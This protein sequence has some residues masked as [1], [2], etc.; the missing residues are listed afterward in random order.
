[1]A[2]DTIVRAGGMYSRDRLEPYGAHLTKR[3]GQSKLT[4]A[5]AR[6]IPGGWSMAMARRMLDSPWLVRHLVIDRWFL[7]GQQPALIQA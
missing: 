7:H 4:R 1:M 5:A 2:A 3:F 6:L